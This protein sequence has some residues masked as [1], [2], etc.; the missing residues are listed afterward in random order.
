[1]Q[2]DA[3]LQI[4]SES[5]LSNGVSPL[6]MRQA[7]NPVLIAFAHTLKHLQYHVI[8]NSHGDWLL[9]T[10]A[11][12]DN[13]KREKTVFYAFSTAQAAIAWQNP[14]A[15]SLS[16]V[17]VPV[18]HLLFQLF[19]LEQVDSIIFMENPSDRVTGTEITR[20]A[21]QATIQKHLQNLRSFPPDIA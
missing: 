3:Q 18:T 9:T 2:L 12:R 6:V 7:I 20:K 4:L 8:Q 16:T 11:H 10:L 19:A 17:I 15:S 1:M 13:P 5:A 14:A 21:L